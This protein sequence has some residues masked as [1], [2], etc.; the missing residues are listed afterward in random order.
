MPYEE[1]LTVEEGQQLVAQLDLPTEAPAVDSY[2]QGELPIQAD[3]SAKRAPARCSGYRE[4]G[5]R[6]NICKN[7]YI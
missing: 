5:H 7:R 4:I 3:Q 2:G 6:I 1:G